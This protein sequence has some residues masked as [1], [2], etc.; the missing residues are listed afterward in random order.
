[1]ECNAK[2][3]TAAV[4]GV[5]V[6]GVSATGASAQT[7]KFEALGRVE[8]NVFDSRTPNCPLIG[9]PTNAPVSLRFSVDTTESNLVHPIN[10][11]PD[12]M[13]PYPP[14]TLYQ[15]RGYP[16]IA[17]TFEFRIGAVSVPLDP[18]QVMTATL[19]PQ[20][21]IRNGDPGTDGV[22]VSRG[23]EYD[24]TVPLDLGPDFRDALG[25]STAGFTMQDTLGNAAFGPYPYVPG[26]PLPSLDILDCLGSYPMMSYSTPADGCDG[27]VVY[28]WHINASG[29]PMDIEFLSFR[30]WATCGIADVA[31]LGGTTGGDGALTVD[32]VVYYL[33]QFFSGNTAVAD[34]VGLGGAGGPDGQITP[35]DL[36]AFLAG[37]FGGCAG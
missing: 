3:L 20:L 15:V 19:R 5:G 4:I 29:N 18:N 25:R 14:G 10:S 17:S 30:I 2:V 8:F 16:I 32:D 35:D 26:G 11:Y 13:G 36:V 23:V 27:C 6:L 33:S 1:M 7:V 28:G 21:V 9:V 24:V 22:L 34:L 12:G 31:G 37:F